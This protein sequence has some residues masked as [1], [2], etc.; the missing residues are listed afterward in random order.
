MSATLRIVWSLVAAGGLSGVVWA[1]LAPPE[2]MLVVAEDRGVVLTTESLHQFDSIAI[3]AGIGLVVGVLSAVAAWGVRRARGPAVLAALV[4]GSGIG[5]TLAALVGM[6]V[7]RL[8]YP[9]PDA[10]VIGDI[11]SAAPGLVTPLVLIL[12]PLA[13]ALIYLLLVSLSPHDDLGVGDP[14]HE[15]ALD[16]RVRVE[17]ANTVN[18]VTPVCAV[19]AEE[20]NGVVDDESSKR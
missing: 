18:T 17:G 15:V 5:A 1:F 7:A 12:Q 6:G 2:R 16:D 14:D 8:R 4:C 9:K 3:F 19:G 10:P 11:L 20:M 13:A